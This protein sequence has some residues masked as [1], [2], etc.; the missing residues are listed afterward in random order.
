MDLDG[1]GNE[2][3]ILKQTK[4]YNM[5]PTPNIYFGG[6]SAGGNFT[7]VSTLKLQEQNQLA[8]AIKLLN[9]SSTPLQMLKSK[10][11]MKNQE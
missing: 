8:E 9:G 5:K 11:Q 1:L 10:L 7:L 4:L 3:E 2:N 6:D